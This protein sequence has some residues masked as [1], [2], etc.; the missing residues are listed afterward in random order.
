[1]HIKPIALMAGGAGWVLTPAGRWQ[2]STQALSFTSPFAARLDDP[3]EVS[4]SAS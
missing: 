1:M 2:P 4:L 3:P